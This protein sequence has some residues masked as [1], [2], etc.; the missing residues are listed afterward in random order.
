MCALCAVAQLAVVTSAICEFSHTPPYVRS[1]VS[2]RCEELLFASLVL[3]NQTVEK[4]GE[5]ASK[6]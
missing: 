3:C 5:V 6:S 4:R 2:S 1:F